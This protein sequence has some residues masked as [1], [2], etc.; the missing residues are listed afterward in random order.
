MDGR[1]KTASS[2]TSRS[3]Q[4]A[5]FLAVTEIAGD[6]VT[7]EQIER[8]ARRYYWAATFCKG[9]DVLEV[10]CGAAQGVGY[11]ASVARSITAGDCSDAVL[12][13]A[14]RHYGSRFEFR[15]FDA[16]QLPFADDAFDLVLIFEALYYLAD[17]DKFFAECRRVLRPNGCLLIV[18]AN[19]DLFDF[20]PSPHSTRYFGVVELWD[21]LG[22]HGF[23]SQFF[24]DTPLS[25]VSLRQR[26]LRPVKALAAGLGMIPDTMHGKKFLKRLVFGQLVK[27]PSE[28]SADTAR[29]IPPTPLQSGMPNHEHKVIQCV[30]SLS[31]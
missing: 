10:A 26:L 8:I 25:G 12:R 7:T 22:R 17:A 2:A 1:M 20:N 15:Q 16:H 3:R 9:K 14:R 5:D 13:I 6:E 4:A 30:A 29:W 23:T 27:M 28:I 24:G 19:K 21:A 31:R 18:S 11:L